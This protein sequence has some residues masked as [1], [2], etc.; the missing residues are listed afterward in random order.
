MQGPR[1]LGHHPAVVVVGIDLLALPLPRH[2]PGICAGEPLDRLHP[3]REARI[4]GRAV[5]ADEATGAPVVTG[6]CLA[7]QQL[8][9]EGQASRAL[10]K[11][12]GRPLRAE[13]SRQLGVVDLEAARHHPA[14]ERAG[15]VPD[16]RG[17][18]DQD[19][20]TVAPQLER[21]RETTV[22]GAQDRDL[23]AIRERGHGRFRRRR[24]LPPIRG[25]LE[26]G[27]GDVCRSHHSPPWGR[28]SPARH[29]GRLG[30]RRE[31][32]HTIEPSGEGATDGCRP[33]IL[34]AGGFALYPT[35]VVGDAPA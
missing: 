20:D 16:P 6:D 15:R 21:G 7:L 28:A 3:A 18:H 33:G 25:I 13:R 22:P 5:G 29:P 19:P 1:C 34:A 30:S 10:L 17:V 35:A 9:Q 26:L 4:C 14:V 31:F 8:L 24:G 2:E 27:R 11:E 32:S 12:R 23:G